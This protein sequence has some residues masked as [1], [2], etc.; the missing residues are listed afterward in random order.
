M[1]KCFEL[2]YC[3]RM[4][5]FCFVI[6]KCCIQLLYAASHQS[7]QSRNSL[8]FC[9]GSMK[10]LQELSGCPDACSDARLE[11]VAPY[12]VNGQIQRRRLMYSVIAGCSRH[13]AEIPQ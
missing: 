3:V 7:L 8:A 2:T 9:S 10:I 4:F 13:V 6:C 12:T 5:A 11:D 1:N